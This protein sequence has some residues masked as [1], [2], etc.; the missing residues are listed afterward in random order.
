MVSGIS[1]IFDDARPTI[2]PPTASIIFRYEVAK[3]TTRS[4][5][6][7]STTV[8][9][10]SSVIVKNALSSLAGLVFSA[11]GPQPLK[12]VRHNAAANTALKIF[13]IALSLQN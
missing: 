10:V 9:P 13:I 7:G 1:P 2:L 4:G 5:F 8:R 11:F 3:L 6:S 12:T